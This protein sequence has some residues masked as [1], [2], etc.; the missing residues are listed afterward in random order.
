MK[1]IFVITGTP[2]TGKTTLTPILAKK[3]GA[4]AYSS[5]S[6]VNTYK[7]Y[8]GRDEFG[9]KIVKIEALLSQIKKIINSQ[10]DG[11]L[12]FEGHLLCDIKIPNATAIVLREHLQTIKKRLQKRGYPTKKIK[13]NLVSEAID[14]CGNASQSNY[15]KCFEIMGGK[16]VLADSLAIV[17]GRKKSSKQI[18]LLPELVK[19][20]K[21]EKEL[22][23]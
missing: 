18:D 17:K 15:K 21:N 4:K 9:S 8:S 19:I 16:K 5:N 11:T 12:I 20:I 14:Y 3:I 22:A 1:R 6:I 23:I 13:D 10:K 7:L 2:G